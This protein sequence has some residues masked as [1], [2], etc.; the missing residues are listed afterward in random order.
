MHTPLYPIGTVARR[1]G[2]TVRALHHYDA[3]GLLCPS[4]RTATG[5]RRYTDADVARL[6][7]LVTLRALGLPLD[8][9]GVL[10]DDPTADPVAELEQQAA[11]V[12][13]TIREAHELRDR[14]HALA[15]LLRRGAPAPPDVLFHLIH[16][17][18]MVESYYTP[19]QLA[20]IQ[21]RGAALGPEGLEDSQQAWT[22]LI[23][24]AQAA[25]AADMA[26][27]APEAQAIAR[28]WADLVRAFTGGDAGTTQNL[29]RVYDDHPDM[30]RSM[31]LDPALMRWVGA[32]MQAAGVSLP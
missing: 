24:R 22:A 19:E 2:L 3:L 5:H 6:R 25:V 17:T 12:E 9:I 7:R 28:E 23:A 1:S 13:A 31:G 21:Q 15:A 30:A 4:H 16:L 11:R 29:K 32:A 14:L 27:D 26:P 20:A 10:L 8:R 18:T